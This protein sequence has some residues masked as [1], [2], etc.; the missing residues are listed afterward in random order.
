[1]KKNVEKKSLK[2]KIK[3]ICSITVKNEG[4]A[5]NTIFVLCLISIIAFCVFLYRTSTNFYDDLEETMQNNVNLNME[6]LRNE[7]KDYVHE[8]I[9]NKITALEE[10]LEEFEQQVIEKENVE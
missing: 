6:V 5:L 8:L 10:D 4:R 7:Q 1:M 3:E 2:V 9:H